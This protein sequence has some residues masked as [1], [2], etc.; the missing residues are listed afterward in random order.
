[1]D[2]E[3]DDHLYGGG[4]NDLLFGFAGNDHLDGGED[5]DW[6]DG[7]AGNDR[8]TGG[9]GPDT[10]VFA[11][12]NFGFSFAPPIPIVGPGRD[13]I[14]DLEQGSDTIRLIGFRT[15][16]GASLQF[17]NLDTNG[18]GVLDNADANVAVDP[19]GATAIDLAPY[20]PPDRTGVLTVLGSFNALTAGDFAFA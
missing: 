13:T 1:M 17:A 18:N 20:A 6:L 10:F 3:G 7:G 19:T 2:E 15:A 9:G 8:L 11:A 5:A 4:E 14:H 12:E 16:S